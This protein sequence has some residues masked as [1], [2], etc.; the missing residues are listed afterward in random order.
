VVDNQWFLIRCVCRPI[1]IFYWISFIT[2]RK[3][4]SPESTRLLF[5]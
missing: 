2:W 1:L 3:K 5:G 4:R